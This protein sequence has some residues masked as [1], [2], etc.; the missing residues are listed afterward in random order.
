MPRLPINDE[1]RARLR[2]AQLEEAKALRAVESTEAACVKARSVLDAAETSLAQAQA[3]LVRVSGPHRAALLLDVTAEHLQR[4]A[5][6]ARTLGSDSDAATRAPSPR[7]PA[8]PAASAT[9]SDPS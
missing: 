9:T 7:P 3:G 4:I 2:A 1:A 8:A 5:K 6:G